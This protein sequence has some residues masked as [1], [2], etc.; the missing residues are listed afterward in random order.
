MHTQG[1]VLTS[2]TKVKCTPG[3]L[4][5]DL[6]AENS[7]EFL[8]TAPRNVKFPKGAGDR[9]RWRAFLPMPWALQLCFLWRVGGRAHGESENSLCSDL[10]LTLCCR[11]GDDSALAALPGV[12]YKAGTQRHWVNTCATASKN[13]TGWRRRSGIRRY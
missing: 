6:K 2:S 11:E 8:S 3:L 5:Q 9:V 10:Q 4:N 1:L 13:K 7:R 12:R